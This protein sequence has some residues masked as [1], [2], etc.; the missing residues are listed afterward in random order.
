MILKSLNKQ[1]KRSLSIIIQVSLEFLIMFL[2]F[3]SMEYLIQS[4][5]RAQE[6]IKP[7]VLD[8]NW[9]GKGELSKNEQLVDNSFTFQSSTTAQNYY[10]QNLIDTYNLLKKDRR[11]KSLGKTYHTVLYED[12]LQN[13]NK[14]SIKA[15]TK[16]LLIVCNDNVVSN[17]Y[18]YKIIKGENFSSYYIKSNRD[19][20][21]IPIL[22]G[23]PLENKNPIGSIIEIPGCIDTNTSKAY[24]F[25][26]IG[27]LNPLYSVEQDF[28]GGTSLDCDGFVVVI[29]RL[30]MY[31]SS[32]KLNYSHIMCELKN[33]DDLGKIENEYKNKLSYCDIYF[34]DISSHLKSI[35]SNFKG[36]HIGELSY[37]VI[38]LT[39]SAFGIISISLST[40]IKR[41]K[42]MGIRF[43]IGAKRSHIITLLV[44]EYIILYYILFL[45]Y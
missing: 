38:M 39:L 28:S 16:N 29:P 19:R 37:C 10:P 31:N 6:V 8:V 45:E 11:I 35:K 44:G 32:L 15:N 34:Y 5:E 20:N 26:V 7:N 9:T 17:Y 3:G 40:L 4:S 41:K 33:N 43:A 36:V 22:I 30:V 27:I 2:V 25:E 24:K 21:V 1:K 23:P 14:N 13:S 42:D 18:N 12:S